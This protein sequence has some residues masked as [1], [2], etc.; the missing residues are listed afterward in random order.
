LLLPVSEPL[1]FSLFWDV[2]GLAWLRRSPK[3]AQYS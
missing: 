3:A 2:D 1:L